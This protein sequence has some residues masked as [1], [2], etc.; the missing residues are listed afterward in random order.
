MDDKDNNQSKIEIF[1][2][3]SQDHIEKKWYW[4]F[5]IFEI[6]FYSST[7]E[8]RSLFFGILIFPFIYLSCGFFIILLKTLLTSENWIEKVLM[9]IFCI[10]GLITLYPF[11]QILINSINIFFE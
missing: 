11:M 4:Y 10:V 2:D 9:G 8:I 1:L 7:N 3:K 6:L 5:A